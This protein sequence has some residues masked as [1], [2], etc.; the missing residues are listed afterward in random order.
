MVQGSAADI[1]KTAL[2]AWSALREWEAAAPCVACIHDEVREGAAAHG[3]DS[4]DALCPYLTCCVE[5]VPAVGKA[6]V[7]NNG[8]V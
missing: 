3:L 1:I 8:T 6:V 5:H 7:G 4:P 2:I